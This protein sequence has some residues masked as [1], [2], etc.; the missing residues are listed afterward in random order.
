[1]PSRTPG[2]GFARHL[3]RN[4]SATERRLWRMLRDRRLEGLKFRRQVPIGPYVADFLCLGCKLIVEADGPF[5]DQ[6]RD[7]ERDAVLRARRFHVLRFSNEM[8]V[9]QPHE[10]LSEILSVAEARQ[11]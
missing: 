3:R 9:G 11:P 7:D 6:M 8:I 10:V 5:H 1:M 2:L 4:P